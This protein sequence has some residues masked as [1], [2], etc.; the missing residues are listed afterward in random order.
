MQTLAIVGAP[1]QDW[2]TSSPCAR[3]RTHRALRLN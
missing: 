3:S 2:V 1:W